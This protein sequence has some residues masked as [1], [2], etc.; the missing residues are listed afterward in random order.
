[1]S[2]ISLFCLP[3]S[4]SS[5]TLFHRWRPHLQK[6]IELK[7]LEPAGHGVRM[8][9]PLCGSVS[10]AVDDLRRQ[11][12]RH[13]REEPYAI[14]GHSLGGLLAFELARELIRCGVPEPRHIFFSGCR[15]P[16]CEP[17]GDLLH[18]KPDAEFMQAIFALGGTPVALLGD[19][20]LLRHFL[21]IIRSDYRLYET[22][23]YETEGPLTCSISVLLG[24]ADPVTDG[25]ELSAW[26]IHTTGQAKHLLLSDANHLFI[27]ERLTEVV[28]HVNSTLAG[29]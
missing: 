8:N 19:P 4:G 7:P 22:Y 10:E 16:Q 13:Y 21:P 12:L 26:D 28:A 25:I 2:R 20:E 14:F 27:S 3:H 15:P 17:Y 29:D 23:V 11:F 6:S 5:A 18:L 1:M 24:D 9:E